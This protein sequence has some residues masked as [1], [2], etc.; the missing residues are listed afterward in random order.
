[1]KADRESRLAQLRD[2]QESGGGS[3]KI[4]AQIA[5]LENGY[6]TL[7]RVEVRLNEEELV[8]KNCVANLGL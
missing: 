6:W 7:Y 2:R 4:T 3:E 5:E 1:V 8:A